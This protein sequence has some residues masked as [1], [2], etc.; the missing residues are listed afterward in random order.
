MKT[1]FQTNIESK[2]VYYMYI[3]IYIMCS[4]KAYDTKKERGAKRQDIS[5]LDIW[6]RALSYFV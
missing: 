4:K 6:Y 5:R 1:L 2:P 3:Y